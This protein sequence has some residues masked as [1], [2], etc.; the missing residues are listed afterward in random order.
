MVICPDTVWDM[1]TSN[2]FNR[3]VDIGV[4][5]DG[6]KRYFWHASYQNRLSICFENCCQLCTWCQWLYDMQL[7]PLCSCSHGA[8]LFLN[9]QDHVVG[10][11]SLFGFSRGFLWHCW[12]T[13]RAKMQIMDGKMNQFYL[14]IYIM[15]NDLALYFWFVEATLYK[16]SERYH[17][18][19]SHNS[20]T[21]PPKSC[22][23]PALESSLTF[24][25]I[26][27]HF[28]RS[29]SIFESPINLC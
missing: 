1:L 20:T 23:D 12:R 7:D 27:L 24:V 22:E 26:D 28:N 5:V 9:Q 15:M 21:S 14:Y 29:A 17:L 8:F 13:Y 25:L 6:L 18:C 4:L 16:M 19:T 10:A 2:Y 3:L 11:D